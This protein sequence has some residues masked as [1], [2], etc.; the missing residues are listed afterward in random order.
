MP[1]LPIASR[2]ALIALGMLVLPTASS[3]QGFGMPS[4]LADVELER[5]RT[6]VGVLERAA[7]LDQEMEPLA[8][9]TRRLQAIAQAIALEDRAIV[10]SLSADD[11][12]EVRVREWFASDAALAR[13]YVNQQD[14]SLQAER[15]AGRETIKAMVARAMEAVQEE[16]AA[17]MEAN[18]E[19][20]TAVG[21][22]EGAIFVRSAVLE[23][24]EEATGPI[25]EN[26]RRAPSEVEGFRFVDEPEAIWQI[27][28]FRPWTA[29]A[30]L[31]PGPTGVEGGR[32]VGYTRVGNVVASVAFMPFFAPTSE[33]P[34]EALTLYEAINDSLGITFEHPEIVF[35]PALGIRLSLPEPL[36]REDGYILHFGPPD[37]ADVVWAAEA[38]TG[39][40]LEGTVPLAPEHVHRLTAGQT[41]TV[42][43]VAEGQEQSDAVYAIG[44]GNTNQA[45]ATRALLRY[46][47]GQLAQDLARIVPPGGAR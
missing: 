24:C 28:Q 37:Q 17:A 46:M 36:D 8:R 31:R 27:Q 19:L 9:R 35:T 4:R 15:T 44:I 6:C 42:T 38:G 25:C 29:P 23:A 12:L 3:A 7:Q 26:A 34:A 13:R 10:D 14:P 11:S 40:P 18:Q 32:T 43:A 41:L 2:P 22:C 33:I 47:S 16:A 20:L 45:Q 39:A 1:S 5:S 30:P 21:P